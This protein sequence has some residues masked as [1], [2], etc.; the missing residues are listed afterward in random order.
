MAQSV[1]VFRMPAV[2]VWMVPSL[3]AVLTA[4]VLFV[5]DQ[6]KYMHATYPSILFNGTFPVE[7]SDVWL[8]I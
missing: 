8:L 3:I 2:F 7:A 6:C 4:C 1:I 5:L